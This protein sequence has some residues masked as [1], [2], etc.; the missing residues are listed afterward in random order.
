MTTDGDTNDSVT[1][2]V[3]FVFL[4]NLYSVGTRNTFFFRIFVSML[5]KRQSDREIYRGKERQAR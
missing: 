4:N 5:G 1:N 3:Y 2:N